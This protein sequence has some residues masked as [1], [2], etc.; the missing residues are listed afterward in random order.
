ML[1][2]YLKGAVSF[3]FLNCGVVGWKSR[4]RVVRWITTRSL[5]WIV[6]LLFVIERGY[7]TERR[8]CG[9]EEVLYAKYGLEVELLRSYDLLSHILEYR[10]L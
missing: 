9:L 2:G 10:I 4:A 6:V 8:Y 3:I 1:H 5:G 7:G